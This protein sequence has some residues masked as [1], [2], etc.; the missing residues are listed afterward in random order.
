MPFNEIESRFNQLTDDL[1]ESRITND[2]YRASASEL[3]VQTDDGA[4]FRISADTGKWLKWI[5]GRWAP[6]DGP[7][8][9]SRE[10]PSREF[11]H[12]ARSVLK[13]TRKY[14]MRRLPI[15][16]LMMLG[17]SALY[18]FL[19]VIKNNG[20]TLSEEGLG[21]IERIMGL[22]HHGAVRTGIYGG[23]VMMV[24]VPI[25]FGLLGM[26]FHKHIA[27]ATRAILRIPGSIIRYS[28]G[29]LMMAAAN[30]ASGAGVGL[31]IGSLLNFFASIAVAIGLGALILSSARQ[32]L[33]LLVH[34]IWN[35][36]YGVAQGPKIKDFK[37][38]AGYIALIGGSIGFAIHTFIPG[39]FDTLLGLAFLIG[40][41]FLARKES[42]GISAASLFIFACF[43]ASIFLASCTA[44]Y[45]QAGGWHQGGS[46]LYQWIR[47]E[48]AMG[49][50]GSS[51]L[52]GVFA[53][54][55]SG[56][57][58]ALYMALK[59]SANAAAG[60][61][62]ISPQTRMITGALAI[63]WLKSKNLLNDD[64]SLN[65][66][67]WSSRFDLL[68]TDTELLII[69]GEWNPSLRNEPLRDISIVINDK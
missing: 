38:E 41:V 40:A 19:I 20:H 34:S 32:A 48:G 42:R 39:A 27:R 14:F 69:G 6:Y 57:G 13:L 68:G 16:I 23:V 21:L 53:G 51:I 25:F 33:A 60:A 22:G 1:H 59:D 28:R 50:L 55:G 52:S 44:A 49:A 64:N 63:Q 47:S 45:A 66:E 2:E 9:I 12:I 17:M 18:F 61:G 43:V 54:L 67:F 46:N 36:T 7:F 37:M 15:T 10:A 4:W 62:G 31:V 3:L 11:R 65:D 58:P 8:D 56:L 35:L 29:D 30:L 5:N 26:F 24:A